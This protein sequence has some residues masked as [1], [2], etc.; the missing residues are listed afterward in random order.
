MP[1][2]RGTSAQILKRSSNVILSLG[3]KIEKGK[4]KGKAQSATKKIA[5]K[6]ASTKA[7]AITKKAKKAE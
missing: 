3:E 4:G 6:E 2:A 5:A 7:K 1:R